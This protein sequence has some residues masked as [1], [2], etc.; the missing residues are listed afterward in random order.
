MSLIDKYKGNTM[1]KERIGEGTYP[2]RIVQI[3]R[4][5]DQRIFHYQTGKP[6]LNKRGEQK[7]LPKLWVT[8]ELPT[9]T[10]EIDGEDKP[11]WISKEYTESTH[12]TAAFYSVVMAAD[13]NAPD[14][15]SLLGKA[16]MVTIGTT[17]GGKDKV[18][19]VAPLMK[20]VKV[21]DLANP[22]L[23]YDI[24]DHDQDVYEKLPEFL[25]DKIDAS[26]QRSSSPAT[27]EGDGLDEPPF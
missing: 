26:E 21:D 22:T 1:K 7:I 16:V 6:E 12:E 4:L 27:F 24:D 8:F 15:E 19:Q 13:K 5:G 18:T 10:I 14:L 17:S 3:I 2:A 23:Y 9:E 25:R 20:G 11:R